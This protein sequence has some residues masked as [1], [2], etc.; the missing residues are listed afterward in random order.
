MWI[1]QFGYKALGIR[2][3]SGDLAFLSKQARKLFRCFSS[4]FPT[5]LSAKVATKP[6]MWPLGL[7]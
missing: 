7:S 1:S 2:L 3:D 5:K 4:P 6:E